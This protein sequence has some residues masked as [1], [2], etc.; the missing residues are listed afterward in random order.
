VLRESGLDLTVLRPSVIFG[1]H[2][3]FLNLFAHLQRLLP[4]VPLAGAA[5]RLQPVWVGDVAEAIV[6][7]L[8]NPATIGQT[9]ELAGPE[10]RSLAQ[11]VQSAG[12]WAGVHGGAG[13]PVWALPEALGR[14]QAR[15]MEWA[16]GEPLMSRDN[17]DSLRVDNVATGTLPG[18]AQLGITPAA[19]TAVAPG[20]LGGQGPRSRLA[21]LRA[22]AGR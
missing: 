19:L 10:V 11:L 14:L 5:A 17:L 6:R 9:F 8:R 22:R 1:T 2:D 7:C 18:L 12:R 4:V 21:A 13:R 20:Y 16:P 3:R 15:L